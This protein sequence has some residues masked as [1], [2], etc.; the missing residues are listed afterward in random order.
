MKK[1]GKRIAAVLSALLAFAFI[2]P[3]AFAA[4]GDINGNGKLQAAD[5]RVVLRY[6]ARLETLSGAQL[7]RADV[8][9]DGRV[10]AAD[11]RLL[12]KASARSIS[13]ENFYQYSMT[14]VYT[15]ASGRSATL[16]TAWQNGRIYIRINAARAL[17]YDSGAETVAI[18]DDAARR[19]RLLSFREFCAAYPENAGFF[20]NDG[21]A[22]RFS[23]L[24]PTPLALED[25]GFSRT[26][27]RGGAVY[28]KAYPGGY[29]RYAFN[30]SMLPTK[31]E[32]CYNGAQQT[33]DIRSFSADPTPLFTEYLNYTKS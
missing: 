1:P 11:A 24:L 30:A 4:V 14:A 2:C 31:C 26:E 9:Y 8:S 12:L 7:R 10:N 17:V 32:S 22:L 3:T 27:D 13:L 25:Q 33:L 23:G 29:Q 5:A 16:E 21:A 6:S 18:V 15:D 19:Y 28:Y 20:E